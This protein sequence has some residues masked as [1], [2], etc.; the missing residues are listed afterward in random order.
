M[1]TKLYRNRVS[2]VEDMTKKHFGVF[3]GTYLDNLL[4]MK[5][6]DLSGN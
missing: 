1:Y 3:F 5:F 2:F 4:V 6:K